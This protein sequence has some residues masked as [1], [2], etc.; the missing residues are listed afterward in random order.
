M[1]TRRFQAPDGRFIRAV[2]TSDGEP[3]TT[4]TAG[5]IAE[6]E[7]GYGVVPLI[8][9][10]QSEDYVEADPYAG[11]DVIDLLPPPPTPE[12]VP[13]AP[14]FEQLVAQASTFAELKRLVAEKLA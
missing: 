7:A 12:P 14:T 3:F 6:H 13:V 11:Y 1:L 5:L 8:L 10:E 9:V 4:D 2:M